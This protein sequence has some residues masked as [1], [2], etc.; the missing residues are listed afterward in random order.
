MIASLLSSALLGSVGLSCTSLAGS[1]RTLDWG[2]GSGLVW[3]VLDYDRLINQ[4]LVQDA[5]F[6]QLYE[7]Y[8]DTVLRAAR[9]MDAAA[10][11]FAQ[12]RVQIPLLEEAVQAA[13]RSLDIANLQAYVV[14]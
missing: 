2:I 11:A 12:G 5:R 14:A 9:E 13:G 8:Q 1:A 7:Q 4:V 10:V 3:N 6:Q